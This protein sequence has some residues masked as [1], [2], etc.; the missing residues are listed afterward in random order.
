MSVFIR[1]LCCFFFFLSCYA[2]EENFSVNETTTSVAT[3]EGLPSSLV[4]QS[5]CAI[6]GQYTNQSLDF[7]LPGP[8][9]LVFQRTYSSTTQR[10]NLG[11]GW[12]SNH[13]DWLSFETSNYEEEFIW[14]CLLAQPSGAKL[15]FKHAYDEK[16]TKSHR[17]SLN[18]VEQDGLTNGSSQEISG[19]TN[20]KNHKV[21]W[22]PKE[23]IFQS[24]SGAADVR[25]FKKEKKINGYC[26]FQESKI[27][28][29]T[30]EYEHQPE[31]FMHAK[32]IRCFNSKNKTPYSDVSI[33]YKSDVKNQ[34]LSLALKTSD[35]REFQYEYFTH[36]YEQK[37]KGVGK[38][39]GGVTAV[40]LTKEIFQF[41]L[42]KMES[43]HKPTEKYEYTHSYVGEGYL[44]SKK[45]LPNQRYQSIKY[46][47]PGTNFL[48]EKLGHIHVE[49]DHYRC[50][51]VRSQSAP[52][53]TTSDPIITHYY[54]YD[55]NT[56]RKSNGVEELRDGFTHVY[57]A[58]QRRTTY[59]YDEESHLSSI[60][61]YLGSH[62]TYSKENFLWGSSKDKGNLKA[63]YLSD[64]DHNIYFYRRYSYDNQGNILVNRLYGALTG[65]N[66][67]AIRL[68][69]SN[70]PQSGC[71]C[72]VKTYT[73]S[74][75]G[76]NL[77]LT[78]TDS[79]G[80]IT[81][82][83]YRKGTD[84]LIAKL[85]WID[86]EIK[87]R[88]FYSYDDHNV[89]ER[90]IVDDGNSYSKHSLSG[91]TERR[92]TIYKPQTVAPIG[93]PLEKSEYCL[94]LKTGN[95]QLLNK[96]YLKY[97]KEG[98]PQEQA[99]HDANDECRHQ[100]NWQYDAHGNMIEEIKIIGVGTARELQLV[101]LKEYD[102]NNNLVTQK[103]PIPGHKN[104]F[105]YDFMNRLIREDE[106]HPNGET[107]TITHQYDY[108]SNRIS[109]VNAYGHETRYEY[110]EFSR[111]IAVYLPEVIDE[112]D[113]VVQ[114]VRRN[115]YDVAGN[116]TV[117]TDAQG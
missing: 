7:V 88:E 66:V 42:E 72:E 83:I 46:Y 29:S 68:D 18:L 63:R 49:E 76:L 31:V 97:T 6:S 103:G 107:F 69:K 36:S 111:V 26:L 55:I 106:F 113:Q 102:K 79:N 43:P 12:N 35:K 9:P 94:D 108:L 104:K 34:H 37:L 25:T 105:S 10:G 50:N 44:V 60:T 40:S 73:Y 39:M 110:D 41:Y 27:N 84:L 57:D 61:K 85:V 14:A 54:L 114:P 86:N 93:L 70:K 78:E 28:G 19:R 92:V 64:S 56:K 58:Y 75:D 112:N 89:M 91:V 2:E 71:E 74:Q 15:F 90:K 16:H 8:E 109:T 115:Q 3:L 101:T 99:Y 95:L 59:H 13:C 65:K 47:R 23:E 20:P 100:I 45:S 62:K 32:S 53:G 81:E 17:L 51:R 52:V 116:V 5:V 22:H 98:Y 4:N 33:K 87:M 80:K 82:N 117:A 38:G 48:S 96:V 1:C 24:V 11:I 67:Q 21:Y 77:L 30:F